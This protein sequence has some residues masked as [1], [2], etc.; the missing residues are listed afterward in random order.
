MVEVQD[1][2]SAVFMDVIVVSR[3]KLPTEQYSR[4]LKFLLLVARTD[5]FNRRT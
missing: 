2:E 1:N 4:E 3:R 5:G